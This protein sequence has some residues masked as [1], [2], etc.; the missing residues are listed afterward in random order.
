MARQNFISP[1]VGGF[2]DRVISVPAP[3]G[4][5]NTSRLKGS[6]FSKGAL[7]SGSAQVFR[8]TTGWDID[9]VVRGLGPAIE[10]WEAF[11]ALIPGAM[12]IVANRTGQLVTKFAR[13]AL[14]GQAG[15]K[16]AVL[17]GDT[18]RSVHHF[19][20]TNPD[21]VTVSIGP[22]TFYAPFIEYGLASHSH[23]GPRPFMAY[24][25]AQTLPFLAQVY[26]D[27]ASF[28]KHGAR[29]QITSAPY[30]SD[31]EKFIARWRARLYSTEKALGG[32]L[33]TG[34]VAVPGTSK[35]RGQQVGLAR[36]LGDIQAGL[37]RT[38]GLRFNRRLTGK[39]TGKLI[40]VGSRTVFVNRTVGA[41]INGGQ[42][43]YNLVAG[44]AVTRF[45]DQNQ[46]LSR[47]TGG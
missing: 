36:I 14:V 2:D 38:V 44:R 24:A 47:F 42:R 26:A 6:F 27:L 22:T 21:S 31:L 19:M 45:I 34:G 17:S 9:I 10:H 25:I 3:A 5:A 40:G 32:K 39:V 1:G 23:I 30:K 13:D 7:Q 12:W 37:S 11:N 15:F 8:P 29:G 35:L 18:Y 20:S 4:L 28:A 43:V 16:P 33:V 46:A 41:S